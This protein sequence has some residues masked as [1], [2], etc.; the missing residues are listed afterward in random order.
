MGK[1][2]IV[3][4]GAS[5]TYQIKLDFGKAERDKRVA[6][7]SLEKASYIA[8]ITRL[9]GLLETQEATEDAARI[10]TEAAIAA[11]VAAVA[12]LAPALQAIDDAQAALAAAEQASYPS[13]E[14]QS[15]AIAAAKALLA[16]AKAAYT[17]AEKAIK[18]TLEAHTKAL[19][20]LVAQKQ[21]TAVLRVELSVPEGAQVA[22]IKEIARLQALL[23]EETRQAWCADLTETATGEV[24]T[25]EIPGEDKRVLIAPEAP[26]P[27]AADGALSAREM[28]SPEQLFWNAAVL[29]GWQKFKPTYRRGTITAINAAADTADV[30][31]EATDKSSAQNLVINQTPTLTGVP[32]FYMSCNTGAFEVGDRA[33]IKFTD[34]DWAKPRVVGFV[35]NPKPCALFAFAAVGWLPL[36]WFRSQNRTPGVGDDW[37]TV[38]D[39]KIWRHIHFGDSGG[40]C[41]DVWSNPQNYSFEFSIGGGGWYTPPSRHLINDFQNQTMQFRIGEGDY[42]QEQFPCVEFHRPYGASMATVSLSKDVNFGS[43]FAFRIKKNGKI[44]TR[45]AIKNDYAL[46]S[47]T[48]VSV[49]GLGFSPG[50]TSAVRFAFDFP[51]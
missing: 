33:V 30:L 42:W 40:V 45:F 19:T 9:S 20:A 46:Y 21:A 16:G 23:L 18:T 35:D 39:L 5:G 43:V 38:N 4:G 34:Q 27:V 32:V 8:E 14:D 3:S 37:N 10:T 48:I 44:L 49:S 1:A 22:L 29:P 11:Y 12:A 7:L 50:E 25:I 13:P 47:D 17:A 6:Q 51:D 36:W 31:L 41:Y 26:A 24:A 2:T 28:Q 15:S